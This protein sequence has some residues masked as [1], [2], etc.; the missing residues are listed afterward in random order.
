[1]CRAG[2]RMGVCTDERQVYLGVCGQFPKHETANLGKNQFARRP[3]NS[4]S[5]P[6][7]LRS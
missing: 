5:A 1:M 7:V 3:M 6:I 2:T 4:N